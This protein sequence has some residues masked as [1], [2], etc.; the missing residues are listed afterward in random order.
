MIDKCI[1][2]KELAFDENLSCDAKILA[3]TFVKH[4]GA[5]LSEYSEDGLGYFILGNNYSPEENQI[6]L[7]VAK[8][9]IRS[10]VKELE[11]NGSINVVFRHKKLTFGDLSALRNIAHPYTVCDFNSIRKIFLT[12]KR[13]CGNL[14][15]FYFYIA[16]NRYNS[17]KEYNN[18]V[19]RKALSI[20]AEELGIT[21]PSANKYKT[22]LE[23]MKILYFLSD[24]SCISK[25][26]IVK[27]L[28]SAYCFWED[29]DRCEKFLFPNDSHK[30]IVIRKYKQS[31]KSSLAM[32]YYWMQSQGKKY[33]YDEM[34][35]MYI[36][37]RNWNKNVISAIKGETFDQCGY[38]KNKELKS[39]DNFKNY[40]F[41]EEDEEI[42]Y[43][44]RDTG[45]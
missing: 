14:L 35:E 11:D 17:I 22:Q 39:E 45:V 24:G 6:S 13:E 42:S 19:G 5:S 33:S 43:F 44:L 34:K 21:Y 16:F 26:G 25:Q 40:P 36:W 15:N 3:I 23:K 1:I 7:T 10:A 20:I 9:R 8:K 12:D 28:P 41:Y 32:K 27:K 31:K 29:R 2:S 18:V 38:Q 4:Y 37:T 30:D